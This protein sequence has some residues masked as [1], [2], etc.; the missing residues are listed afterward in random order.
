[1]VIVSAACGGGDTSPPGGDGDEEPTI[2]R[3]LDGSGDLMVVG[4]WGSGTSAQTAVASAMAS[5]AEDREMAAIVTTG[6][7]LYSD[8]AETLMEPFAW[9]AEREIPF[10]VSWGNHDIESQD[11]VAVVDQAFGDPPLWSRHRWGDVE[12]VIIDSNQVDSEAQLDFLQAALSAGDD[13]TVIV[14]HHPPYSCG[15]HGPTTATQDEWLPHFDDDVF[16]VLSGHE[17]NYQRFESEDVTFVVTGGGG[18]GVT[19]LAPCPANHP[20]RRKGQAVNHFVALHQ[21]EGL[22]LTAID[23]EGTVLDEVVLPLP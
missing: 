6:D 22:E 8:D 21:G 14:F 9:V 16:L 20:G 11:R 1:V 17:H 13:P 10:I 5:H 2:T 12:L 15:S 19:D 4:D 18:A 23:L 7:N 3:S